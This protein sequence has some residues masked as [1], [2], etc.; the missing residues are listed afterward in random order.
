MVTGS[1]TRCLACGAEIVQIGGGHRIRQYCTDTCKQRAYQ[2]RKEQARLSA[3]RTVWA[4]YLPQTQA[5]L[6][7]LTH[8][9]SEAFAR[10]FAQL[11]DEEKQHSSRLSEVSDLMTLGKRL[12]Y[13]ELHIKHPQGGRDAIIRAGFLTWQHV[14]DV[15]EGRLIRAAEHAAR[16][17][18][19]GKVHD[20]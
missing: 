19:S 3:L 10:Q 2:E 7:F 5:F 16:S 14:A 8:Q 11:I 12:H 18:V 15:A 13:C 6:V 9:Y 20:D 4:G 17:I 1:R